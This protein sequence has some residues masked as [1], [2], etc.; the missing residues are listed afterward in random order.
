MSCKP[1][2]RLNGYRVRKWAYCR[3]AQNYAVR[4]SESVRNP[5]ARAI[6][7]RVG[8]PEDLQVIALNIDDDVGR[9][10][11]GSIL[12]IEVTSRIQR[13]DEGTVLGR[14][15]HNR[16]HS[17]DRRIGRADQ[18]ISSGAS[19]IWISDAPDDGACICRNLVAAHR[20]AADLVGSGGSATEMLASVGVA[21]AGDGIDKTRGRG[22]GRQRAC[23]SRIGQSAIRH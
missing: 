23:G 15:G 12:D 4:V 11:G 22:K 5:R 6:A 1:G 9:P 20:D 17:A 7:A 21:A 13:A 18:N 8:K 2:Q 10:A 3:F 14:T 19:G 16:D